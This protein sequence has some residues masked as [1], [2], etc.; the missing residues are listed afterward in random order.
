MAPIKTSEYEKVPVV[1]TGEN[2]TNK[3][4]E[5]T[6]GY[7]VRH[8]Q[9][10]IVFTSL[11]IGFIV[12]SQLGVTIVAMTYYIPINTDI[13][14]VDNTTL[15][16]IPV[17]I[18]NT[19]I[20]TVIENKPVNV[21]LDLDSI[22][23]AGNIYTDLLNN[24]I[25]EDIIL[26]LENSTSDENGIYK[27]YV[28]SKPI[29]ETILTSFFLGYCLAQFFMSMIAQ[30]WGGKIPLQIGL[31]VNG[32]ASFVTP[33]CAFWGGWKAVC[34]CRILQGISQGGFFPSI[35]TLLAQ[36]IPPRERGRLSS[37]VYTG[38]TLGTVLGFQIG[39]ILSASPWGWPSVFWGTGILCL[40]GFA[41]LTIFGAAT[42]H[43]HKT[44]SEEERVYI[45]HTMNKY[46]KRKLMVP[47]K[48][49]K[50]RHT[51]AVFATH[52]GSSTAFVFIFMQFPS[53]I[54]YSLGVNVKDSGLFSSLPYVVS[55]FAAIFYGIASDFLTNRSI[56]SVINARRFFNSLAQIGT[57]I[58]LM[59]LSYTKN[60]TLAIGL[61][62]IV[63]ATHV[64]THVGW[65]V[66]YIDLTANYSGALLAVGNTMMNM[67]SL[68][69]PV[70]VSNIVIDV[71]NQSQW[72]VM[73]YLIAG[74][75]LITN[76]IFVL[77]ISTERQPWDDEDY[78][79]TDSEYKEKKLEVFSTDIK[80][81]EG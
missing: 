3:I 42:P 1:E 2:E 35:Q 72:R 24:T 70:M 51:W 54:H 56:I 44:I 19:D 80:K 75:V 15:Q 63:Q 31:F 14:S 66:N 32:F 41:M 25:D 26:E 21:T 37:F 30:R 79:K 27:K 12:R 78:Q 8:V 7:G 18:S 43:E 23:I 20:G 57:A 62:V 33:W 73:F 38:T 5:P 77:F 67:F 64:A 48:A 39:G 10:L 46:S 16:T 40:L 65:M 9:S 55:F 71:A 6:Y 68:I 29:Q 45:T 69:L 11:L 50:S 34:I 60:V 47:L 28:W 13:T 58:S 52:V 49:L 22:N 81:T 74:F 4:E 76:A 53:Y 61:Q 17:N 59:A 36:W